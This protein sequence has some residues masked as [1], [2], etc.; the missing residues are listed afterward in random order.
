MYVIDR[1][2]PDEISDVAKIY[3][4]SWKA[5]YRG[6]VP[7]GFLDEIV[8]DQWLPYL[9]E[10]P[11]ASRVLRVDERPVAT[12]S[13]GPARDTS[14]AGSCRFMCVPNAWEK[15]TERRFS[16]KRS[17]NFAAVAMSEYMFGRS[18]KIILHARFTRGKALRIKGTRSR[19]RSGARSLSSSGMR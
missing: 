16:D 14:R 13:F 7:D 4:D 17:V 6:I 19:L 11:E 18:K 9:T 12:V 8:S 10:H 2:R 3:E 1:L 15:D 5:A